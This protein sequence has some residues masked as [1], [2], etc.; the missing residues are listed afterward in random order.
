LFGIALLLF[1]E[2]FAAEEL[3]AVRVT[4]TDARE[5]LLVALRLAEDA[6]FA[7]LFLDAADF[8]ALDFATDALDALF[9]RVFCD[10]ACA[11]N[12]HA[13][14]KGCCGGNP[15]RSEI[16]QC[17]DSSGYVPI[18]AHFPQKSMIYAALSQLCADRSR[19]IANTVKPSCWLSLQRS[20]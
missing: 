10:T 8:E 13:P 20:D 18:I 4:L 6:F 9:L 2:D 1:L 15:R 3:A 17:Q 19:N 14:V 11:W 16:R 7:D 12:C 5:R